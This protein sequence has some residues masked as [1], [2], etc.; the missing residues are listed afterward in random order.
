MNGYAYQ[1]LEFTPGWAGWHTAGR[2]LT[3]ASLRHP[4]ISQMA[5]PADPSH[6]PV[7]LTR[8]VAH[9]WTPESITTVS[10][11]TDNRTLFVTMPDA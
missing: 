10:E 4:I 11:N 5:V 7:R 2:A 8:G 1:V 3:K 6:A 9:V